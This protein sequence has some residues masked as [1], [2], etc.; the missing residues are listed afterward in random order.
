MLKIL[1]SQCLLYMRIFFPVFHIINLK[2]GI[3]QE[4]ML[5]TNNYRRLLSRL[6]SAVLVVGCYHSWTRALV[7]YI[8]F[9]N[10]SARAG[11]DTGSIFKQSLTGLNSEFSLS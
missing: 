3:I 10:P 11:Y 1:K 9:T 4:Y 7:V 8:I 5:Y 6:R 2:G